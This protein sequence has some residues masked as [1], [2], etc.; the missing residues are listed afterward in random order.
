M[1]PLFNTGKITMNKKYNREE[2]LQELEEALDLLHESKDLAELEEATG[3][4][5]IRL[6]EKDLLRLKALV[7]KVRK[8]DLEMSE[9]ADIE[10]NKD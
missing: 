3:H 6:S 8:I 2:L 5:G 1:D 10:Q 9:E 7:E 4:Q